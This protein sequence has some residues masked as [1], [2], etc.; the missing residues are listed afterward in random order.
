MKV[1]RIVVNVGT[2]SVKDAERFYRDFLGLEAVMDLGWIATHA[3]DEVMKPQ[4]SF[5][6]EGGSGAAV[7][8]I[9]SLLVWMK[10]SVPEKALARGGDRR[11]R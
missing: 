9:F 11:R 1:L 2:S 5:A 3:S 7:P 10:S 4:I 8:D 6:S